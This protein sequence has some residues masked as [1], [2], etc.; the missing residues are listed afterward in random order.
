MA[1]TQEVFETLPEAVQGDYVLNE[2]TK[3][4]VTADSLKFA[5]AKKNLDTAYS[6]RDKFKGELTNYQQTEVDRIKAAEAAAYEKAIADND[7]SKLLEMEQQKAADAL[8][9]AGDSEAKFN[10]LRQGLATEKESAIIDS[11]LSHAT[12]EG[13]FALGRLLK[14]YVKVDPATGAET[15]LN[16]DGSASSLNREQFITEQLKQNPVFT[17]LVSANLANNSNGLSTGSLQNQISGI[18]AVPKTLAECKGDRK[19]EAAYF[20]AQMTK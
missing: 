9:R 17:S 4:Y 13:K 8:K 18:A 16:D 7:T 12:P 20:N 3:E 11:L 14:G 2:E 1:L 10:E 19:K 6:E 5:G 15:Y